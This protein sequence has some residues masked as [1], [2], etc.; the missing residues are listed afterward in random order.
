MK[1][2]L[3]AFISFVAGIGLA[4]FSGVSLWPGQAE[5]TM[6]TFPVTMTE[7]AAL[8]TCNPNPPPAGGGGGG[9]VTYDDVTNDLN[10]NLTFSNLSGPVLAA[11]FHGPAS[12]SADAGVQVTIA[13]MTSPSVG[14][15]T[16]TEA[17]ED[18]LLGGDWYANYHTSM[19]G[20]GEIRGQVV[21]GGVGGVTELSDPQ[22]SVALTP[23]KSDDSGLSTG[24]LAGIAAAAMV[25]V[26][27]GAMLVA[28]RLLQ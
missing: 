9:T 12:P 24:M 1:V 23:E 26:A 4:V 11:H 5:A 28:R 25:V 18:Q 10:W 3:A 6:Y 15:A 13:D 21:G 7:A 27:G 16:L 22:S 17:Q 19:C 20:G 14:N 8:S 2:R